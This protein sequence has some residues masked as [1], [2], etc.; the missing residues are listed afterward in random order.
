MIAAIQNKD[1][2]MSAIHRT[3]LTNGKK[4][5]VE[6]PKKAIGPIT[7][8]CAIRLYEITDTLG[9]AE[10]IETAIAA[11][12]LF[13]LPVW[14]LISAGQMEKFDWPETVKKM[15]IFADN[16]LS[17]T[18]QKAAFTLA[19]RAKSKGLRVRVE[20]PDRIADWADYVKKV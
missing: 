5:E 19:Y 4:A 8:G 12:Q 17:F 14:S 7:P 1:G 13:E 15:I 18:G 20:I 2:K 10:G 6:Q 11:H 16:D 9:V 3:Y